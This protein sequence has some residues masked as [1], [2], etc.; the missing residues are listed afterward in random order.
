MPSD[1]R[2]STCWGIL[3][4]SDGIFEPAHVYLQGEPYDPTRTKLFNTRAEARA[5]RARLRW[6][7]AGGYAAKGRGDRIYR[8][9][10]VVKVTVTVEV[11]AP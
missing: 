7:F 3:I 10:R 2:R 8:S 4:E 6:T 9:M 1:S 5:Y 11:A